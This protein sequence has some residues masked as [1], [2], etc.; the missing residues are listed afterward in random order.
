M[1]HS[2]RTKTSPG[3]AIDLQCA[4]T[5]SLASPSTEG[6]SFSFPSTQRSNNDI[7]SNIMRRHANSMS[8]RGIESDG[9]PISHIGERFWFHIT[10]L[11]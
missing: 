9:V 6:G 7:F 11:D 4:P 5:F 2:A 3:Q 10:L 1:R 8:N